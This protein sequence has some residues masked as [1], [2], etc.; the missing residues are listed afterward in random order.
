MVM[1]IINVSL[2]W[3]IKVCIL[4]SKNVTLSS[5]SKAITFKSYVFPAC[6]FKK[7]LK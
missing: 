6:C 7:T 2:Y 5:I 4:P 1:D 3:H